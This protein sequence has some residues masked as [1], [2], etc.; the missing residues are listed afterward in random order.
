VPDGATVQPVHE[1]RLPPI[2]DDRLTDEQREAVARVVAGP[3]GEL[4][5]NWVP[6]L[7]SP[8]MMTR[9]QELGSYLRFDKEL[10]AD[11]F[12]LTVLAVARHWDNEFE[13]WFHHPVALEAGVP[14]EVVEDVGHGRR[15]ASGRPEL[16]A[17]WDL[18]EELQRTRAVS[19]AT[20]AAALDLLGEQSLVELVGTV[21]YYT[22]LAMTM[23]VAGTPAP[24][25]P[26]LP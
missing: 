2:P 26:R 20:Y 16:A 6:L 17:A 11:V 15:P 1:D 10:D 18:V 14:A 25:G 22:T 12:E 5:G 3:R 8:A 4:A 24:P 13:W 23:N 7:R 9:L 19:D 21:G